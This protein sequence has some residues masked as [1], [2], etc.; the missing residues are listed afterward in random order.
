MN[1]EIVLSAI[2]PCYNHAAYVEQTLLGLQIFFNRPDAEIIIVDDG[3]T[4][5]SVR[6][7]EAFTSAN[8]INNIILHKQTNK[9]VVGA[10]NTGISLSRGK[11]FYFVGSDD[12]PHGE[13][14]NSVLENYRDN[15]VD[16][17][18]AQANVVDSNGNLLRERVYT[19]NHKHYFSKLKNRNFFQR[20]LWYPQPIFIQSSIFKRSLFNQ[21]GNFSPD[22]PIDDYPTFLKIFNTNA[23]IK[24]LPDDVLLSYRQHSTNSSKNID[25]QVTNLK[26]IH[27]A[28][29]KNENERGLIDAVAT[30]T[31]L[32]ESLKNNFSKELLTKY[33]TYFKQLSFL[34]IV[35]GFGFY[36]YITLKR[37]L[38]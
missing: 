10:L 28:I 36:T 6:V 7:L 25:K 16:V 19:N 37:K 26:A 18:I 3:S 9:G 34:N 20:L 13:K 14:I 29:I 5:P 11:Y 24:F 8:N 15:D 1:S 31:F 35:K 32:N 4:D 27:R 12:I 21:I 17:I 38:G 2:I 33:H 22:L 30:F 23:K